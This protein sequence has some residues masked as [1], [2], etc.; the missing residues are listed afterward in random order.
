MKAIGYK[1]SLPVDA[2]DALFDFELPRPEAS[3]HDILVRVKA[4]SV[5]PVDA[6][7]RKRA[8]PEGDEPKILGWDAAG[9]VDSVGDAVTLFRPGDEVWYAGALDRQGCNSEF[10]LVDERIAGRKPAS[11][12]FPEAAA[13]PLTSI[14]AWELLFDRL[15]LSEYA[16]GG[17]L[18]VGA[19]GGVGS[20]L[21]QILRA[22]TGLEVF[23][24]ASREETADW[25]KSLGAHHV[26]N[27]LEPMPEKL[28]QFDTPINYI[29]SLTNTGD[30]LAQYAELI[31][32]QGRIAVIDDPE[33]IDIMPFKRKS[34]S[35][36][37]ELMFTRSLYQTRDMDQQHKLLNRVAELVD[38]GLLKTTLAHDFGTI[39][40]ANLLKA[41]A[42]LESGKSRGKIVLYGWTADS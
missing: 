7:V 1:R 3:G 41:H 23:A 17:I 36:H 12:S 40:A 39:N 19:G 37:W 22:L 32:P 28:K 6:K 30:Y 15:E 35:W 38:K 14:T 11:L 5:N 31:A 29:A 10:H 33:A 42:L 9:V 27:H 20:I 8:Q 13:L 25:V 21:I 26:I 2:P 4:I 24:T 34:V 16:M 18:I